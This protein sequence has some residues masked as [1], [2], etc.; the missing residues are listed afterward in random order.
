MSTELLLTLVVAAGA[1]AAVV[2]LLPNTLSWIEARRQRL[3]TERSQIE[4]TSTK[5]ID[6]L[7]TQTPNQSIWDCGIYDYPPLSRIDGG[8]DAEPT[9]LLFELAQLVLLEIGRSATYS[10]VFYTNFYSSEGIP[11]DM[12]VGMFETKRRSEK[13]IFS[14]PIYEIGLQGIC[15]IDQE[16][17]VI[18]GLRDGPLRAA[19]YFGEVGWEF[20]LDELPDAFKENRVLVL[21]G[22]H[23]MDTM[24][25]LRDRR[26][27]VVIMD[28]VACSNFI[29]KQGNRKRFKFALEEP[30]KKYPV[31]I[32]LKPQHRLELERINASVVRIRNTAKF[33]A[34]EDTALSGYERIIAK[35]GLRAR[36]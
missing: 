15:R 10:E 12:A 30:L 8:I 16:G 17:D 22:G 27:D 29:R 7:D 31:C 1:I 33:L 5:A 3:L 18:K 19:V 34:L 36:R 13:M 4:G 32:G 23:Q 14:R 24:L 26:Y 11:Q 21:Q 35:R 20:V 9:G 6:R 25:H 28:N 2:A